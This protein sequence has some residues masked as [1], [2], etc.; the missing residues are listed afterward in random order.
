[1][2][3]PTGREK[4]FRPTRQQSR[5]SP[6]QKLFTRSQ[7]ASIIVAVWARGG[8]GRREG[9]RILWRNPCRFD[10]CR[11]H[12][13][14]TKAEMGRLRGVTSVARGSYPRGMERGIVETPSH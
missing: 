5:F 12:Q 4:V 8:I 2:K 7:T 14:E 6:P 10:P 3:G 11:A 13:C 1:M 9:L